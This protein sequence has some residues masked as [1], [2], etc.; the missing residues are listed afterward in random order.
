MR[1]GD[2][3]V[4]EGEQEILRIV[5]GKCLPFKM[6]KSGKERWVSDLRHPLREGLSKADK[7]EKGKKAV[8]EFLKAEEI[9]SFPRFGH[10]R[11]LGR[12]PPPFPS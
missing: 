6:A 7:F 12:S 3:C 5:Q 1:R 2:F 9:A 4:G 10:L 8:R 11:S